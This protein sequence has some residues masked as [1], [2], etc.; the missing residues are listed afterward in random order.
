MFIKGVF[1]FRA[2]LGEFSFEVLKSTKTG[3]HIRYEQFQFRYREMQTLYWIALHWEKLQKIHPQKSYLKK[4]K[5]IGV[6]PLLLLI[7]QTF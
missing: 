1:L 2:V 6:F 7:G 3:E 4:V 5:K